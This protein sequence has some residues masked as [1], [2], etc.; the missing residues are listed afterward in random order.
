M[1][2]FFVYSF[3][4]DIM[5]EERHCR[6]GWRHHPR[7]KNDG[8]QGSLLWWCGQPWRQS[9]EGHSCSGHWFWKVSITVLLLSFLSW[10]ANPQWITLSIIFLWYCIELPPLTTVISIGPWEIKYRCPVIQSSD[11]CGCLIYMYQG[12]DQSS[13]SVLQSVSMTCNL[14]CSGYYSSEHICLFVVTCNGFNWLFQCSGAVRHQELLF[15]LLLSCMLHGV[16]LSTQSGC[17]RH[18]LQL[19]SSRSHWGGPR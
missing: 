7:Q 19:H 9:C 8:P 12:Q 16:F 11:L 3:T 15:G 6:N 18:H 14:T 13:W 2:V 17:I 10:S 1:L 4:A 5:P